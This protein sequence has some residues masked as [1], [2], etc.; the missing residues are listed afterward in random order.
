MCCYYNLTCSA[1]LLAWCAVIMTAHALQRCLHV[2]CC[3]HSLTRLARICMLCAVIML[4]CSLLRLVLQCLC[5]VSHQQL[6]ISVHCSRDDDLKYIVDACVMCTVCIILTILL[7][8][9]Y[10]VCGHYNVQQS[11]KKCICCAVAPT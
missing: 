2:T 9:L 6:V 4:R 7:R 1:Q 8:C 10:V 5:A 11:D 3:F